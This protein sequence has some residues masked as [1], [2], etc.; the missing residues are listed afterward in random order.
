MCS[1]KILSRCELFRKTTLLVT[2]IFRYNLCNRSQVSVLVTVLVG[3]FLE[4]CAS[5]NGFPND[6][7]DTSLVLASLQKYFDPSFE[8]QYYAETNPNVREALRDRVVLG[9]MRAY[10]IQFA[11]FQREIYGNSNLVS[12]GGDIVV[13]AANAVATVSGTA[14]T[15]AALAAGSAG[16]VGTQG[17][18][19]KDLFYQR[20]IPALLAQMEANRA[21]AKATIMAGLKLS[22]ADY[23]LPQAYIDLETLRNAAGIPSAISNVTEAASKNARDAALNLQQAAVGS[24]STTSSSQ[25][26]GRWADQ[27]DANFSTLNKW[28]NKNFP[29][30]FTRQFIDFPDYE[31]GRL[32]A[33]AV[34]H[35]P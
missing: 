10:D 1:R 30:V 8:D 17:A 13:L 24:F 26:L 22:D 21:N 6:P 2:S 20:T 3:L 15:K 31:A 29:G 25:R 18:I 33:I 5:V 14:V 27:S 7:E 11:S 12:A 28:V 4:S 9:Q 19:S 35:V 23:S 34:F 32:K 16:V